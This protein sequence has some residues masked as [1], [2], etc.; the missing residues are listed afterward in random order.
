MSYN[1]GLNI[2]ETDGRATPSIQ[3]AQTSVAAFMILSE[4]GVPG[5]V[6]QVVNWSQFKEHFGSYKAGANGAYAL[7]GFFD[8]GGTMAYVTRLVN[9]KGAEAEAVYASVTGTPQ[10]PLAFEK[11]AQLAL[12]IDGSAEAVVNFSAKTSAVLE[13]ALSGS[14]P[15]DQDLNLI[16][17]VNGQTG[18]SYTFTGQDFSN[19]LD[20]A[21]LDEIAAVLNR[22]FMGIQAFVGKEGE[23]AKL[24]VRTDLRGANAS[25]KA[26]GKLAEILSLPGNLVQGA[27]NIT[28]MGT[29]DLM[30]AVEAI[31]DGLKTTG[32]RVA[33]SP[34]GKQIVISHT[35][36]GT[37]HTVQVT[38]NG[39]GKALGFD[40]DVHHGENVMAAAAASATLGTSLTVKA[41]YMGKEDPGAWGNNL[42]AIITENNENAGHYDLT[43]YYGNDRVEV[44]EDMKDAQDAA[45]TINNV[46]SGSK[47]IMIQSPPSGALTVTSLTPLTNG[48]D[49]N[50]SQDNVK[51]QV[52]SAKDL[53]NTYD[54]QLV[55]CPD[56]A[57][58][59]VVSDLLTYCEN[60]GDCMFVGHTPA[61]ANGGAAKDYGKKFR[62][63]KVYGTL[64][65]PW[66]RVY[67][68]LDPLGHKPKFIPPTG[69][70]LGVYARTERERGI[71]KAPAGNA[72]RIS[73]A[74]DV[75]YSITDIEHTDMVKN[76]SVN[77][78]R[79]ISGQGIVVDSSRTLST[80]T[81]WLY[82]NVR[83]L[84]NF[85]KS[86]LKSGLRW[87][88]QE[89]N[90]EALWNKIKYNS[91][92]PFLMGLWRQG[93]F[94]PGSPE[95]VFTVKV[96]AENNPDASIQQG[97]LSVEVYFY[98]SRPA[99]TIIITVGQQEGGATAGEK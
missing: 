90:N 25:L 70:V 91:V 61:G 54:V 24:S 15:G 13:G 41:G 23:S 74:L 14:L 47:F 37:A 89:P 58:P 50:L 46:S 86:S 51:S 18:I 34:G 69:H 63:N 80:S 78:V 98:P 82:V 95:Q 32:L 11:D 62:G 2:V 28:N 52:H 17:E 66:I 77:A 3:P 44:W 93:A 29:V 87:V 88:V 38:E 31:S 94:G 19:G 10:E 42:S 49:D 96:D 55:C 60:R 59:E 73:G 5:E 75:Q 40:F 4:R 83:L 68:P 65:F 43:V 22:E 92:T 85:V 64:Y 27:G 53:F 9:T 30:E 79:F 57:E 21:T 45:L 39:T 33:L 20:K 76:G 67:D 97:V 99:E 1:V 16:L 8:N 81:L 48:C 6:Y 72:A 56:S 12:K 36:S 71:W 84:F 7:Q 35:M 26:G